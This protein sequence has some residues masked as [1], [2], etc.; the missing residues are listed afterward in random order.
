M[1][2]N[3]NLENLLQM[4]ITAAK[5]GN[6]DGAR[7]LLRQVIEQDRKNER[8]WFWM[9]SVAESSEKRQQ[10]L[11]AVLKINPHHQAAKKQLTKMANRRSNA[12]QR[13]LQVGIVV[14]LMVAVVSLLLF[15][16]VVLAK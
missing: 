15:L 4:G 14:V 2:D 8:A 9:A 12:E 16:V 1:A 10:Y 13:T 3:P 7:L 6:K 11:E 5:E